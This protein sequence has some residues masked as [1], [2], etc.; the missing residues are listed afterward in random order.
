METTEEHVYSSMIILHQVC[1]PQHRS[2]LQA[3]YIDALTLDVRS[4]LIL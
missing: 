2:R 1:R 4:M 3:A